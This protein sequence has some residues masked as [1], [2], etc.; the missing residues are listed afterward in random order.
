MEEFILTHFTVNCSLTRNTL[1]N[2][3]GRPYEIG[4]G[5]VITAWSTIIKV[6][7]NACS[8]ATISDKFM[9]SCTAQ[10]CIAV[11]SSLLK[12]LKISEFEN[13]N[14][15]KVSMRKTY[16]IFKKDSIC[17]M[18]QLFNIDNLSDIDY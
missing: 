13:K 11:F 10:C 15:I 2:L 16:L 9:R 8:A 7:T 17:S 4:H 6:L 5:T 14:S 12:H 3:S 1:K 18:N